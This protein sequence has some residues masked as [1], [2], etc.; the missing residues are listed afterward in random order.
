MSGPSRLLNSQGDGTGIPQWFNEGLAQS[1]TTE[2]R[3]RT[4]EDFKRYGHTDARAV[5]CD[6]NGNVD[7]FYHGEYNYGCYTYFYLAVQRLLAK[8]GKD[9]VAKVVIALHDGAPLPAVIRRVT[10]MA[11]PDYQRDVEQYARD[12]FSGKEAIP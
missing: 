4:A 5:I 8:G 12:V 10:G 6:L 1:V 7:V 9:A 3:E 11:W 2:G